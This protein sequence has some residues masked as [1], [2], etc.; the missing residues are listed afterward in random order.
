[1][2]SRTTIC[3]EAGAN[4]NK[5]L[6]TAYKLIDAAVAAKADIV[7]FQTY[8]SETL[9]CKNTPDFGIYKNINKLIKDIE[10]P[11]EWQKLLK[12][13]CNDS[14][15]EFLST[16]FDEQAVDEL[17][18]LGVKRF[19]IGG[20]EATDPRFVKYVAQTKLPLIISA[21][22]GTDINVVQSILFW[23]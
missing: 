19:K 1:M 8:S 9:Y 14:G 16:P 10:L 7:K 2:K 15:I 6:G 18:A 17:Y 3:A 13:Y 12:S 11:R 23:I 5:S 4:F 22:I 21:G 20:F